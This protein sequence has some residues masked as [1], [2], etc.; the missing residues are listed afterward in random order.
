[1]PCGS[2]P[3][4]EVEIRLM[5]TGEIWKVEKWY[6]EKLVGH[7]LATYVKALDAPPANKMVGAPQGKK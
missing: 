3:V 5:E 6:A 1:M 2:D 4:E 7:G